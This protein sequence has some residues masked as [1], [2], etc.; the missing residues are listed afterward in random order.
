MKSFFFIPFIILAFAATAQKKGLS[1]QGSVQGGLLEGEIGSAFQLSTINGV[2]YKTWS[3]GLGAGIDYYQTRSIPVFLSMRKAFGSG[4]KA[5][6]VYANGGYHFPWLK[7]SD[8]TWYTLEADG[9]LY[10]DAGI[11]YQLPVFK[12][13]ALFFTAGFSQKN[14]RRKEHD[15][16]WIAIWPAPP[17]QIRTIEQNL[18]RLSIQTGIRF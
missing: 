3:A 4:T 18:R 6:F 1:Y 13:S 8:K 9:G 17:P 16:V 12:K 10:Y 7:Q 11:G 2:Q 14:M 5:P 15:G